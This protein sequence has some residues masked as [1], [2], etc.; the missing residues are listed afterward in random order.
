MCLTDLLLQ[1]ATPRSKALF[2]ALAEHP[3]TAA[4]MLVPALRAAHVRAVSKR[5]ARAPHLKVLTPA[6]AAARMATMPLLRGRFF[7]AAGRATFAPEHERIA[8]LRAAR[9]AAALKAT[10]ASP[11][12]SRRPGFALAYA[13]SALALVAFLALAQ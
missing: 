3:E 2:N 11:R 1:G 9:Q 13:T 10:G 12:A 7:D 6:R 5:A 8:K 4:A